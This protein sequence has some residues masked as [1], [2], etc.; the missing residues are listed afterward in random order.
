VL[1]WQLVY[2]LIGSDPVRYRP[3]MPL[4]ALAKGTFVVTL[5]ALF[6]MARVH[7]QWLGF[8][9][10]DGTFTVLFLV[11]YARTASGAPWD[12]EPQMADG[13]APTRK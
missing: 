7:S 12:K 13:R 9:A 8:V 3:V 2:A 5:V 4:A 1:V 10:F 11:A 6:A